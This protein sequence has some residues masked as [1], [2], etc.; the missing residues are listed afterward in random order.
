[1]KVS[2]DKIADSLRRMRGRDGVRLPPNDIPNLAEQIHRRF[3]S[4]RGI[5]AALVSIDMQKLVLRAEV[6][7]SIDAIIE[8]NSRR[9]AKPYW[10]AD[11]WDPA[12]VRR[13][14]RWFGRPPRWYVPVGQ[15]R[16]LSCF[17]N[18]VMDFSGDADKVTSIGLVMKCEPQGFAATLRRF[19]NEV[20]IA[21]SVIWPDSRLDATN[22][23]RSSTGIVDY[24]DEQRGRKVL[25]RITAADSAHPR[26]PLLH[27][28]VLRAA[29][30]AG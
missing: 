23:C 18:G 13:D 14:P 15:G 12:W 5:F 7:A 22:L 10:R 2:V 28:F 24:T 27:N 11:G 16:W 30:A 29:L 3:L 4:D 19:R 1:M 6:E 8:M 20:R 9:P 25:L 26:E 17:F 21:A